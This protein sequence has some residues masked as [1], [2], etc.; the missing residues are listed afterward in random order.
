MKRTA[1][2]PDA[3]GACTS[4][5]PPGRVGC[6][7]IIAKRRR[8]GVGLIAMPGAAHYEAGAAHYEADAAH[9]A[10]SAHATKGCGVATRGRRMAT[11]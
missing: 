2:A 9:Y 10:R 4:E 6:S 3:P 5:P 11:K 7:A 8:I 1:A